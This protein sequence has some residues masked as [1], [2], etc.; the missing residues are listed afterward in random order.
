M[1][2]IN[3]SGRSSSMGVLVLLCG[4]GPQVTEGDTS[5]KL[6]T[7]ETAFSMQIWSAVSGACTQLSCSLTSRSRSAND[8]DSPSDMLL[9]GGR[10]AQGGAAPL[11]CLAHVRAISQRAGAQRQHAD[12]HRD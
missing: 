9:H 2:T 8:A 6:T 5:F 3:S 4:E 11:P 10:V 1:R 7:L 12:A